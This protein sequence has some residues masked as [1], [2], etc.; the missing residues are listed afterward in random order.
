[1]KIGFIV[2]DPTTE[3]P[4]FTTTYLARCAHNMG[5]Q[6]YIIGI[7]DLAYTSDGHLSTR[8]RTVG[9]HK[10]KSGVNF[11]KSLMSSEAVTVSSTDLDVLFLRND[12]AEELNK[13][14]WAQNPAY[15]FG[16][17]ALLDNVIVLNHPMSLSSAI[18]KM[19]FQHFPEVLRP[20][21]IITRDKKE[22]LD[23]FKQ[24]NEKIILKPLQGSGGTNV[25]MVDKESKSNINQIIEAIS[26]D[27]YII[28]QEYLPRATE[29]DTRL[30]LM[31]GEPLI[32]DGK[33]AAIRRINNKGDIRSNLHAGGHVAPAKVDEEMLELVQVLRPKL[34]QDGMFLVGVDIV[35][36]KLME[37][38][39]FSP[40]TLEQ[41]SDMYETAFG[42]KVISSIERKVFYKKIYGGSVDNVHIATL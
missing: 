32:S 9:K 23:F 33:Y 1:M 34:V 40:G 41:M 6:V 16:Q 24:Q 39:V 21:A 17:I 30:F 35:G 29:G 15:I 4:R 2:N 19:Y 26:R 3:K 8:A 13:R 14:N 18:N 42:E 20:Q 38:N 12:P 31:N 37:V 36:N 10:Y 27:G 28:A 7:G 11:L 22:I 25:F 5:H